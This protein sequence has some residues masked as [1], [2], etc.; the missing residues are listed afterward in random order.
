MVDKQL[1]GKFRFRFFLCSAVYKFLLRL[2]SNQ[3]DLSFLRMR[4]T[5]TKE[6]LKPK[7]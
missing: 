1:K 7:H 5:Y 2:Y 4:Q 3:L 6:L